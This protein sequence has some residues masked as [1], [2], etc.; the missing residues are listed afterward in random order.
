MPRVQGLI[1]NII[2]TDVKSKYDDLYMEG[3]DIY[4]EFGTDINGKDHFIVYDPNG[5]MVNVHAPLALS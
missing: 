3:L 2:E 1:V 5:I 4:K